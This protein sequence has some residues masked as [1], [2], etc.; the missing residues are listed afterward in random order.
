MSVL[1]PLLLSVTLVLIRRVCT[2]DKWWTDTALW[3]KAMSLKLL[4]G[5]LTHWL[6]CL[7]NCIKENEHFFFFFWVCMCGIL[8]SLVSLFQVSVRHDGGISGCRDSEVH[9]VPGRIEIH[10]TEFL[11][12]YLMHVYICT[13]FVSCVW[14]TCRLVHFAV[15]YWT[16]V[17][18][19]I[20]Q[21]N[22]T[23]NLEYSR[24]FTKIKMF[25]K[26][27]LVHFIV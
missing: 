15:D 11:S 2:P 24:N 18:Y 27:N 10:R 9:R 25:T 1:L 14:K 4:N 17:Y 7:D 26:L 20:L 3:L 21:W 6:T 23:L 8:Q 12:S 22:V 13:Y 16:L 19:V 5:F